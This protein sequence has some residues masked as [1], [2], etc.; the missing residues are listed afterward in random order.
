MRELRND[1]EL[2]IKELEKIHE[3]NQ[4]EQ[5][6]IKSLRDQLFSGTSVLESRKSV[7]QT[8]ITVQQGHN[9]KVLTLVSIFFLPLTFVTSIFGMTNMPPNE[10]FDR[11]GIVTACICLPTYLLIG[12][13]N[14]TKGM[15]FWREEAAALWKRLVA[16]C[17]WIF[18]LFHESQNREGALDDMSAID[19]KGDYLSD[20]ASALLTSRPFQVLI[21]SVA[22]SIYARARRRRPLRSALAC[23]NTPFKTNLT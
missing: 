2:A 11:F 16:I 1:F 8:A 17:A 21:P 9:I 23:E 7:Q 6:D 13:L 12:S 19:E 18:G 10:N 22:L 5:K 14:T 3:F 4:R 15:A 20:M